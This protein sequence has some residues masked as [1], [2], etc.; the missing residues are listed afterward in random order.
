MFM[1]SLALKLG[2]TVEELLERLT[3][4]EFVE[5]QAFARR[6]PFGAL[7]DDIRATLWPGIKINSAKK[8]GEAFL[9][10]LHLLDW[11]N[12]ESFKVKAPAPAPK[13]RRGALLAAVKKIL[14]K[15]EG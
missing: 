13:G 9:N 11:R 7:A 12:P 10:P 2:C 15:G 4:H 3:W 14:G 6:E 8:T 1:F 5:W